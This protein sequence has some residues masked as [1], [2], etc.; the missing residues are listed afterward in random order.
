MNVR[1]LIVTFILFILA[2]AVSAQ[3]YQIR[4]TY[5]TNLRASYSLDSAV[6][7]SARAGAT[8]EVTGQHNR[9]LR[10]QHEGR[11]L[12]MASWVSHSRVQT[13]PAP[14]ADVDN[15]CDVNRQCAT[16][17]EWV[18]GY[19]AYQRNECPVGGTSAAGS[20]AQPV[21]AAPANLDN[22]CFVDR[23]CQTDQQWADGYWAYQNNQCA[24]PTQSLTATQPLSSAPDS[25]DNCCF[26]GWQCHNDADWRSGYQAYQENQCD[27]AQRQASLSVVIPE[28]VDNCCFVNRQC[29]TEQDWTIGWQIFQHYQ[30]SIPPATQ[31]ISI[32]G[33]QTFITQV[34]NALRLLRD[35]APNWWKYSTSGLNTIIMVAEGSISGVYPETK[36]Y[37]ETLSEVLKDGTGEAG[38]VYVI[39]GIVHEACHVHEGYRFDKAVDEEK[40]CMEAS[41][42]ALQQ[43]NPADRS[44][45]EW[46][47]WIIANIHDPEI[48]W[49]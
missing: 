2:A 11:E 12:W 5:N 34:S 36:T 17:K 15:C 7:T 10:V 35:E 32:Q 22:C 49:W 41:L 39:F 24:A 20:T 4:V 19:W 9:W 26:V 31:G 40:A 46:I 28:G 47:K 21:S 33:S 8:V 23:Q 14:Q 25:V 16:N 38:L 42:H 13:S 43:I 29:V 3:T 18:D 6:L 45:I 48:Q 1:R 37:Q 30:C 27:N 44:T